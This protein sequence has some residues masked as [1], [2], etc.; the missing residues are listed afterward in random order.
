MT[1]NHDRQQGSAAEPPAAAEAGDGQEAADGRSL[2]AQQ[3]REQRRSEIIAAATRVFREKGYHAASIGD[4]IDA[5]AIARG[6]FYL[7]FNSKREIF[8]ELTAE[9]LALIRRSVRRISLDEG[10][11]HPLDQ[12][13]ANFRRVM[14]AVIAHEDLAMIM[15]SDPGEL[16]A[17]SRALMDRFFDQII[18]LI[19]RA[20]SVG[21]TLGFARS[22]D[23]RII[24]VS[25]LGALREVLRRM[26]AARQLASQAPGHSP[27][28]VE[29]GD[30][31]LVDTE[32][33]AD[34]LVTFFVR[35][36]FT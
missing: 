36:V 6:T 17:E 5:A 29:T 24:A 32:R 8:T 33:L 2:R 13:R 28:A 11:P 26:L 19:E 3:R 34:E 4:I 9:F 22:C 21:R 7:Y 15:L 23:D 27:A 31:A 12:M 35:G 30:A 16:D 20:V 25:A 14:S 10:A 18:E 1:V